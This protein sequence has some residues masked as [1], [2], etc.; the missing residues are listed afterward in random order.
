[1][2]VAFSWQMDL[3]QCAALMG[4]NHPWEGQFCGCVSPLGLDGYMS[5]FQCDTDEHQRAGVS[6]FHCALHRD[7]PTHRAIE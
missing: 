4:F 7:S 5:L 6:P 1:M 3:V 2:V